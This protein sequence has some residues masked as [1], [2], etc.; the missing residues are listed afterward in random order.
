MTRPRICLDP[1]HG[2]RAPGAVGLG[3]TKEKDVALAVV[4]LLR[5][6]LLSFAD[7][8]LTRDRDEY[9]ELWERSQYANSI[10]ANLFISVHCNS[11]D[12]HNAHGTETL[13]YRLGGEAEKLARKVQARVVTALGTFDRGVKVRNDLHVLARTKMPAIL[14]ELAFISNPAE[15]QKLANPAYQAKA[16]RAIAQ[17][18]ADYLGVSLR[19]DV[20]SAQSESQTEEVEDAVERTKVLFEGKELAGFLKDGKTYVEVRTLCE[21]LGLKVAWN[22]A[23]K[24]VEVRR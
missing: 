20:T 2:G 9:R 17:G 15:E 22:P 5:Q 21:A 13:V 18:V 7:V 10:G 4:R 3:G 23:T 16:A 11:D 12:N 1:G 14:V 6:E 19:P 24:T 8:S